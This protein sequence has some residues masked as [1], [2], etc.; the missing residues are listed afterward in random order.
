M[1]SSGTVRIDQTPAATAI[2]TSTNTRN[3][4]RAENSMS[5]LIM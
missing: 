2:P 5:A 1:A 3:R 4:L